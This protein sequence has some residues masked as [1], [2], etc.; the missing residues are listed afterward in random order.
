VWIGLDSEAPDAITREQT[1]VPG[2][3]TLIENIYRPYWGGS[4]EVTRSTVLESHRRS[5]AR[6]EKSS[7]LSSILSPTFPMSSSIQPMDTEQTGATMRLIV[8]CKSNSGR[9]SWYTYTLP[10]K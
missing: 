1:T 5:M 2:T 9:L 10:G 6:W 4:D 3:R 8:I 7:E